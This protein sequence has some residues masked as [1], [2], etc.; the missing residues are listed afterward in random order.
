[1]ITHSDLFDQVVLPLGQAINSWSHIRGFN[2]M[3]AFLNDK[4]EAEI[5]LKENSAAF[6]NTNSMLFGPNMKN[7]LVNKHIWKTSQKS[8]LEQWN[9]KIRSPPKT[10]ERSSPF[11]GNPFPKPE[12]TGRKAICR[13]WPITPTIPT[14]IKR[15]TKE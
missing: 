8:F 12:G 2:I 7:L 5:R 6:A 10:V 15:T 9:N 3:M 11:E 13:S 4:N 1:M 14:T